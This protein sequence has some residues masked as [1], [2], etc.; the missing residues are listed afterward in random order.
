MIVA[1]NIVV[2]ITDDYNGTEQIHLSAVAVSGQ[3]TF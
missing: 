3:C 2:T 1:D